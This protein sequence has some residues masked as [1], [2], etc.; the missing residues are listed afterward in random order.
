MCDCLGVCVTLPILMCVYVC[1]VLYTF[2]C[3]G[4]YIRLPVLMCLCVYVYLVICV[5]PNVLYI[6]I[7]LLMCRTCTSCH[8]WSNYL[9][10]A[11]FTL[12]VLHVCLEWSALL[13][14]HTMDWTVM[15]S[16]YALM[17]HY[18]HL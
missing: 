18:V 9:A 7:Y 10:V 13:V 17:G 14:S 1:V 16:W 2:N 11:E 12:I 5:L 4:M 8:L 3:L 6:H 15:H